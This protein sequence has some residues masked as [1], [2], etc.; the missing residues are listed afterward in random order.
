MRRVGVGIEVRR[1]E[2]GGGK[3]QRVLKG[4]I[5]GVDRLRSH[6][7]LAAVHRLVELGELA[8]VFEK[9]GALR[10]ARARRP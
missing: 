5:D 6:P 9:L 7:P 1:L 8:A 3:I 10:V 2:D 4:K